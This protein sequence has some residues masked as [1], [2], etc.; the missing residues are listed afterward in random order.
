MTVPRYQKLHLQYV[1]RCALIL[2]P[3]HHKDACTCALTLHP[4]HHKQAHTHAILQYIHRT[5]QA[6]STTQATC[7]QTSPSGHARSQHTYLHIAQP[8]YLPRTAH[9]ASAVTHTER[10][11]VHAPY[12]TG[13]M[14]CTPAA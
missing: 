8:S 10:L 6:Q 3:S 14:V 4:T 11:T 13:E 2:Q 9:C 1:S 7:V 5:I 12:P